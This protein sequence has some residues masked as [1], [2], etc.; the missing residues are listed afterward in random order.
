MGLSDAVDISAV[1]RVVGID[2]QFK[3]LREGNVL[4]LPQRLAVIGQGST[5]A[6]FLTTKQQVFSSQEAGT[7]YGFGSP[8]HLAVTQLLPVNGDGV[9][10]IPVTIYPLEDDGSG[11][12]SAGDITPAGSATVQASYV[13]LV[14]NIASEEFVIPVGATVAAMVTAITNAINAVLKM[15]VIATDDTTEVGIASKWAG[16]SA[17]DIVLEV[18]GPTDAGVTFGFTQPVGGLVNPDVQ[19]AL[20]QFGDV[21]ET[22]VL[23]CVR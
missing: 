19:P 6:T 22:M 21:W 4:F 3:D 15:P 23:N 13:V 2:V 14:N 5:A 7:L 16:T 17:N 12:A 18:V 11:V 1:G 10:T 20:D 9:G 8:V